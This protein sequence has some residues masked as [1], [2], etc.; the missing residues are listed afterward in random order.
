[1]IQFQS[2]AVA[3]VLQNRLPAALLEIKRRLIP[4][5]LT[6]NQADHDFS[7]RPLL[8][9]VIVLPERLDYA[10]KLFHE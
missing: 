6:N 10:T 9:L 7:R 3:S 5:E 1:M 2:A 8:E 4:C